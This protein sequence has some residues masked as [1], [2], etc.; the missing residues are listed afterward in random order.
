MDLDNI[1]QICSNYRPQYHEYSAHGAGRFV[2][3]V[4]RIIF[5]G[6]GDSMLLHEALKYPDL[7]LVVGLEIDQ[8]VVRKSFKHFQT[9]PHFEDE[10]VEWWF[11]DATKSLL[12]LPEDYWGSFDLVLV[13]LSETVMSFSVTAELD[14]FDALSLLLNP[15]GVMVK[16][17]H[18]HEKFSALFDYSAELNYESPLTTQGTAAGIVEIMNAESVSIALDKSITTIVK[19]V[20]EKEGFTLIADP[21][22]DVSVG[23]GVVA[24]KEGFISARIYPADKYVAFDINL[25]GSSS[26]IKILRK[27]L[28]KAV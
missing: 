16:N 3:D 4:R 14:V 28:A 9:S 11:G 19:D 5:I 21:V 15:V 8:S 6:G 10:R 7:E 2:K 17:E 22:F 23:V 13:D 24:M 27:A 18:Y 25:W 1:V 26:K 12:L 20:A